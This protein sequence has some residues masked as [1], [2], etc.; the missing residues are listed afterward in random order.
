MYS[1]EN[2]MKREEH[3]LYSIIQGS[4]TY[5]GKTIQQSVLNIE[6]LAS[7][8]QS[9]R[10]KDVV[11]FD[12]ED[13]IDR[14]SGRENYDNKEREIIDFDYKLKQ[15]YTEYV[16]ESG[17]VVISFLDIFLGPGTAVRKIENTT[18][19]KAKKLKVD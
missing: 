18:L 13:L 9:A 19:K 4:T 15:E 10:L 14:L 8:A 5:V 11:V 6:Y 7:H 17:A 2:K 3:P 1:E 16:R 12:T